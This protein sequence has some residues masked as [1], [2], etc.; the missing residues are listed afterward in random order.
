[1]K[2][3]DVMTHC[4]YK[5]PTNK[6]LD[7]ALNIMSLRNIRHLPVTSVDGEEI[8]GVISKRDVEVAKFI[9]EGA[10][11]CPTVGEVC[12]EE[13]NFFTEETPVSVVAAGM[14]D[15][16]IDYVLVTDQEGNLTGIF[17]TTDALRVVH[18]ALSED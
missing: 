14:A 2:I 8:I 12:I 6:T 7:E 13:P 18:L 9:C 4:P 10:K 15:A 3:G 11:Y 17:T 1:M 5:I 16:K